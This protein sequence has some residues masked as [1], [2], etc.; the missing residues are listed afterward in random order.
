MAYSD[1]DK[2][3]LLEAVEQ[4]MHRVSQTGREWRNT[5]MRIILQDGDIQNAQQLH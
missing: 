3:A 4:V 5:L 1:G 2:Q